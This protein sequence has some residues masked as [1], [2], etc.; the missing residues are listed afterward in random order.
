MFLNKAII[1]GNLTRDPERKS[2]PSGM[3]VVSLGVATNRVYIS[4]GQKQ[5]EVEFHNVVAFGKQ[6]E[7]IA[8]YL[9]KGSSLLVEGRLKTRNWQD[10]QGQKHYKTEIIADRVQFGPR[11]SGQSGSGNYNSEGFQSQAG[12][13]PNQSPQQ[14]PEI[15][16]IEE[17]EAKNPGPISSEGLI[18]DEEIDVKDIPF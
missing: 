9:K 3:A 18:D 1:F 7:V 13:R 4:N 11:S 5:E 17:E 15:P 16:V 10:Q 2:L 14:E 8:Q 6:A 12:T